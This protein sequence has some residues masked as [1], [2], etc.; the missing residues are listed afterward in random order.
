MVKL[1]QFVHFVLDILIILV[2]LVY[3]LCVPVHIC[4]QECKC[5]AIVYR[6]CRTTLSV[7]L[8][9][10][11]YYEMGFHLHSHSLPH[12]PGGNSTQ[13]TNINDCIK[14][15]G[16]QDLS[17]SPHVCSESPF[18]MMQITYQKFYN[19]TGYKVYHLSVLSQKSSL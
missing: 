14:L 11:P 10:I 15:P 4:V 3:L 16:F 5:A 7:R 17:S 18:K 13:I 6:Y 12:R 9:L 2:I 19:Y 1:S 8:S